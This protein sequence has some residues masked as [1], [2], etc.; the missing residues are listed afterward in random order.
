MPE[1]SDA[2]DQLEI[3]APPPPTSDR[4]LCP[5][6]MIT[7]TLTDLAERVNLQSRYRPQSQT[8]EL[9][10]FERG[11]WLIDC[12][13]WEPALKESAWELLADYL[14]NGLVGWGTRCTRDKQF[15]WIRLYCWGYVVEYMYLVVWVASKRRVRF[16]GASWIGAEGKS[17]VIIGARPPSR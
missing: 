17:V 6:D 15:T 2:L 14:R 9:R 1:A 10:P 8:R 11:Y 7:E 13:S 3:V 16:T 4:E 5:S 12:S